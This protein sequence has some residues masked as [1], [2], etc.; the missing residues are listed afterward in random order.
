MNSY[1]NLCFSLLSTLSPK[2]LRFRALTITY[3]FACCPHYPPK[4][5]LAILSKAEPCKACCPHYP[6]K[7]G[8]IASVVVNSVLACCPHYPPKTGSNF[9]GRQGTA[10]ACCPHYPPK[11]RQ[12]R[13]DDYHHQH[14]CCPHYPPKTH[15]FARCQTPRLAPAVHTIP[16][17]PKHF[18]YNYSVFP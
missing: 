6:P 17:K 16:Q 11:T 9:L 2:N 12:Q 8:A 18:H 4:T 13:K 10:L 15:Q 14:A 7:T 1:Q 3:R 5:T